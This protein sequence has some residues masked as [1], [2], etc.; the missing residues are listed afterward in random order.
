MPGMQEDSLRPMR[1][2]DIDDLVRIDALLFEHDAWPAATWW[3]E[4]RERPRRVYVVATGPGDRAMA[5][6]G[7]DVAGDVADV[8]T[9]GV[10][11]QAQGRGLGQRLLD[12]LLQIARE[13]GV[14]A[15][16]LEVRADNDAA[17]NLYARNGFE[18]INVR[19]GYYQ[20]GGVDALVLRRLLE[21]PKNARGG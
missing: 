9:I 20:P 15:V 10:S 3:A 19:R 1:W 6:G 12:R 7:L 13:A 2:T 4:L 21:T 14:E 8:M 16:L 5:Y 11:P 17:R 18:Q